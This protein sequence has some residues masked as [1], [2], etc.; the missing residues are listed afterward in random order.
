MNIRGAL[1][2]RAYRFYFSGQI[3]SLCGTWMQEIAM[4]WLIY[5]I[6]GSAL[7]LTSMAFLAQVPI[8]L[9]GAWS[10]A[11]IDKW[12]K[13]KAVILLQCVYLVHA[14]LLC[15]LTF[16][17][18]VQPWHLLVLAA[19]LGITNA[20][21][22][23]L[24][25][26]YVANVVTDRSDLPNA[27]ALNALMTNIARIVGPSLAGLL[28][29]ITNEGVCFAINGVSY[30]AVIM[31]LILTG[32]LTQAAGAQDSKKASSSKRFR[33]SVRFVM[34][35]SWLKRVM[36]MMLVMS[37]FASPY[38]SVMP[39]I[40]KKVFISDADI[41]GLFM[42]C[43][44]SGALL[45]GLISAIRNSTRS[46][47]KIVGYSAPLGALALVSFSLSTSILTAGVSLFFVGFGLMLTA[48]SSNTLVQSRVHDDYRGRVLTI[49]SMILLGG[50][51]LGAMLL[52]AITSKFGV[53]HA[54]TLTTSIAVILSSVIAYNI[55]KL[56]I[57]SK[58]QTTTV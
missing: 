7:M 4:A 2:Y 55:R 54:L 14:L 21:D 42:A 26:V 58:T 24:R 12:N 8:L 48:I 32:P 6:T 44:A 40:V 38:T 45:A 43:S 52:G 11:L 19:V 41:Y 27:I 37:L 29:M 50:N 39:V 1:K 9:V 16:T 10:G 34:E 33:D 46:L 57:K 23:P 20:F 22:I 13:R 35:D 49:Y 25:Q 30:L 36:L 53:I 3:V 5:K 17:H 31:A 47:G 56:H 28:L 18:L 51:P 15:F